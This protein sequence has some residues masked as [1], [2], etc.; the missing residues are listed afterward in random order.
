MKKFNT[1]DSYIQRFRVLCLIAVMLAVS[2]C[3]S[4][5]F[6]YNQGDTLLYWWVNAYLDL[7]SGQSGLVKEDIGQL[8]QWHR[9]TQLKDYS[10]LL[11]NGQKQLAGNLT[12]GDLKADYRDIR[13]RTELLAFKALPELT[14]LALSIK[15]EQIAKMEEKFAKNNDTYRKKFVKIDQ[16]KQ[17]KL[18]FKKS[19]E[20]FDLWFGG[21]SNEQETILKRASDV[22]PLDN[23]LW[24]DERLIRQKRIIAVLREIQQKKLG[25]EQTSVVL[26]G[27]LKEIFGRF[28]APEHKPFFDAYTDSTMQMILTA[29]KIATPTQ[30][31]HAQ[32]RMQGWIDDFKV[33]AAD[34]R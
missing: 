16:D 4:V 3:S 15:P 5:K 12:L 6:A 22:R 18:R 19:M 23:A 11:T 27:L 17:Q 21:F 25:K 1:Q 33:L 30:K 14:E 31:A 26:N 2:A 28:D 32:K 13:T 7:D 10:Q 34:A 29:V 8:F 20:Q 9:K 24:L